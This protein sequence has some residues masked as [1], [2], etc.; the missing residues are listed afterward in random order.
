MGLQTHREL[1]GGEDA[2]STA[3]RE[4]GATILDYFSDRFL[5]PKGTLCPAMFLGSV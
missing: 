4:V 3:D 1:S 2:T 5:A